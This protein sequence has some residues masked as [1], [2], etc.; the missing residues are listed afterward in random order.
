MSPKI[1]LINHEILLVIVWMEGLI[2]LMIDAPLL[3]I[4]NASK[5]E[6]KFGSRE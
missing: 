5:V 3:V 2:I 1:S 4:I 6:L